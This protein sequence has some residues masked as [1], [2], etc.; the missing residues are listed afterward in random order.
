[1]KRGCLHPLGLCQACQTIPPDP[2]KLLTVP[3][4]GIEQ[5]RNLALASLVWAKGCESYLSWSKLLKLELP[6]VLQAGPPNSVV[7]RSVSALVSLARK[8]QDK[9]KDH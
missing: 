1:M 7:G 5:Q 6:G 3:L 8:C 9:E 4:S 2:A